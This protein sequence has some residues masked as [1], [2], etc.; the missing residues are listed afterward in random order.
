[1]LKSGAGY[2]WVILSWIRICDHCPPLPSPVSL[3]SVH[4]GTIWVLAIISIF[5]PGQLVTRYGRITLP[6]QGLLLAVYIQQWVQRHF[7]TLV[8]SKAVFVWAGWLTS[9]PGTV[10]EHSAGLFPEAHMENE[11][12]PKAEGSWQKCLTGYFPLYPILCTMRKSNS[13]GFLLNLPLRPRFLLSPAPSSRGIACLSCSR[14]HASLLQVE[15]FSTVQ[16]PKKRKWIALK[17]YWTALIVAPIN[18]V[19]LFFFKDY[20]GSALIPLSTLSSLKYQSM[21]IV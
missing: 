18:K 11:I 19:F 17:K 6:S 8:D 3:N 1:M 16:L 9:A 20:F 12:W 4:V 2:K 5:P 15:P 7:F 21:T 10:R 13:A 14:K